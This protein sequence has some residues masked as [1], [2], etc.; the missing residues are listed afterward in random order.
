MESTSTAPSDQ[1]R[2]SVLG[3]PVDAC[4]DVQAAAI[5]LHARGGG[6]I[7]TLNAEMTMAAREAS[8]SCGAAQS[9]H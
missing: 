3:V 7:V 8:G 5:G 9:W 2:R 6:Q 4:R 1:Y